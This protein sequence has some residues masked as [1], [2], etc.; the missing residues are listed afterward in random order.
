MKKNKGFTLIELLAVIV[1]LAIIAIIAVPIILN[2]V[3]KS[4]ESSAVDS[5]YGYINAIETNLATAEVK[6][7]LVAE[8][9]EYS[10]LREFEETYNITVKGTKPE[11]GTFTL[12]KRKVVSAEF[13]IDGYNIVCNKRKCESRGKNIEVVITYN[14]N[15]GTLDKT[16][17]RVMTNS[18][19][20]LP[21][22]T[23]S[24]YSFVGWYTEENGGEEVTNSTPITSELTLYARYVKTINNFEYT[25]KSQTITLPK[26][27]YKLEV[28]GA[29]G[30]DYYTGGYGGYASGEININASSKLYIYVGGKPTSTTGGWNGGGNGISSG[31]GGG[32]ATDISLQGTEDS[33]TWNETNHIYSRVIVAGGGGGSGVA[34]GSANPAGCGGGE[35]G[36]EGYS[37]STDGSNSQK[38]GQARS[39]GGGGP[40]YAGITWS[41]GVSASFGYGSNASGYSCGGGGGGWYGGAGA[42]DNDSDSDGRYGG[43]GSGYVYTESTAVN[44][45]SG[46]LLNSAYYLT[47]AATVAGNQQF[48]APNGNNET[49]H[50]GNGYARITYLGE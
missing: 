3:E 4:R 27:K 45:P 21:T 5:A 9:K 29:Q 12:E 46:C 16:E 23:K 7:G 35:Y 22:P 49:G 32:G 24:D 41:T 1:I 14:L 40:T 44:Y 38:T 37:N 25:G 20:N 6:S 47:N 11:S 33:S 8:N 28:W 30:G 17:D 50:T 31:R 15:G 19:L 34:T 48:K 2:V 13:M 43:G 36:G 26:G 18:T 42:Y 39:G 10:N